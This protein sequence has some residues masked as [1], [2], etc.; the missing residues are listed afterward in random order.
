MKRYV[1][2]QL[3]IIHHVYTQMQVGSTTRKITLLNNKQL[4]QVDF[5][6]PEQRAAAQGASSSS[7][8]TA[9]N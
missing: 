3:R 4:V 1:S 2:R 8:A 5:Y 9:A 6:A 7:Q